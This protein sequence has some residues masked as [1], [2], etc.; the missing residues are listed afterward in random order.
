M[1]LAFLRN[2]AGTTSSIFAIVSYLSRLSGIAPRAPI[3]RSRLDLTFSRRCASLFQRLGAT[4]RSRRKSGHPQPQRRDAP[5]EPAVPALPIGDLRHAAAM[6]ID[7]AMLQKPAM[8]QGLAFGE[9]CAGQRRGSTRRGNQTNLRTARLVA[10]TASMRIRF[11]GVASTHR[12]AVSCHR[13]CHSHRS[14]P[15]WANSRLC[16]GRRYVAPLHCRL[17]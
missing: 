7:A 12:L 2:S 13:A 11:R 14:G 10:S 5:A 1:T 3:G 15:S 4:L 17:V 16:R 6:P 9:P 8:Q